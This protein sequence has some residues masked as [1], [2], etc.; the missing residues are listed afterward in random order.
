MA[1]CEEFHLFIGF[2][3]VDELFREPIANSLTIIVFTSIGSAPQLVIV[4]VLDL[5]VKSV[6]VTRGRRVK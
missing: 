5:K 3:E 1:V 2:T 6:D 4:T